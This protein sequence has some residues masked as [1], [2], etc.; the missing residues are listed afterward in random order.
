MAQCKPVVLCYGSESGSTNFYK[1]SHAEYVELL[2]AHSLIY[3]CDSDDRDR[4]EAEFESLLDTVLTMNNWIN[5]NA[6]D[7]FSFLQ[8]HVIRELIH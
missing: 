6:I 3:D 5:V 2:Y 8:D 4:V 1:I 7:D